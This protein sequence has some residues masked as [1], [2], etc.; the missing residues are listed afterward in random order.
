MVKNLPCQAFPGVSARIKATL[1][2]RPFLVKRMGLRAITCHVLPC[3]E[4]CFIVFPP[5]TLWEGDIMPKP[6]N[7]NCTV[8]KYF[9]KITHAYCY[10]PAKYG[11]RL[12]NPNQVPT[13]C[14]LQ[15]S[16]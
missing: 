2:G 7:A 13:W 4:K 6:E 5:Y 8:C 11:T 9:M 16:E 14:P 1:A 12:E 10:H 3:F 15:R